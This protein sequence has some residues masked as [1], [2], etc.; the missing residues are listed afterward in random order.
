[1][2]SGWF[3]DAVRELAARDPQLGRLFA[4]NGFPPHWRR[5][6]GFAS[7]THIILEQQVS[8]ASAAAA[9]RRLDDRLDGSIEPAG[10]SSLTGDELKAIGF[11]RQK[12]GYVRELAAGL[13]SGAVDLH[14][15]SSMS[16][17]D[18]TRALLELRGVGPWTAAIYLMFTLD[19]SDVWPPGDRA[20]HVAMAESLSLAAPPTTDDAVAIAAR[21][22][23]WRSAAA[24]LLWHDYLGGPTAVPT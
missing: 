1:M 13:E 23:P 21:W 6:P 11:S 4:R 14:A 22:K 2:E 24:R 19:R 5:D 12:A 17:D 18:A 15:V 10:F 8:L 20:L 3:A 9:F 7:L 16:D